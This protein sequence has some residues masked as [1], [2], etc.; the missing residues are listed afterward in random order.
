MGRKRLLTDEQELAVC[1][2]YEEVECVRLLVDEFGVSDQT[3]YRVLEKHGIPRTHRHPKPKGPGSNHKGIDSNKVVEL[4]QAGRSQSE[5][6]DELGCSQNTVYY[7]LAKRGIKM[8]HTKLDA[9]AIDEIEREY[10]AGAT[11]YQLGEKYGVCHE[12]IGKWMHSRGHYRGKGNSQ[13]R[14]CMCPRCGKQFTATK[15]NQKYCSK[16]CSNAVRLQ[17]RHD[18]ARVNGG[19]ESDVITLREVWEHDGGKCYLCGRKTDWTDYYIK[20]GWR[21]TGPRYPTREHV[22]ALSNGGTH[23][24]DNV[25]LACFECNMLKNNSGQM[26]L[27]IAI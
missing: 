9:S 13:P 6:A 19:G 7:H 2:R 26:R 21:V 1:A 3:I 10:L 16:T 8:Q 12:T 11:T 20:D 22:I 14:E 4:Y 5:I 18:L 27:S 15:P 17:H 25:R 24:W 23:T